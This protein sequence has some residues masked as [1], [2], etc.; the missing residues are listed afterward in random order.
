MPGPQ[1][2]LCSAA[3]EAYAN[4]L[5]A[6]ASERQ[7]ASSSDDSNGSDGSGSSGSEAAVEALREGRQG[8][9]EPA[10]DQQRLFSVYVHAPPSFE[11]WLQ[12]SLLLPLLLLLLLPLPL[13]TAAL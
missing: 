2:A 4:L 3:P 9:Q 1:A 7:H 10:L 13:L 12:G 6:C 5:E 8:R 11:G